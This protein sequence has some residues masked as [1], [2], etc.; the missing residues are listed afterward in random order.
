[1]YMAKSQNQK[2][3]ELIERYQAEIVQAVVDAIKLTRS[4]VLFYRDV[5][6]GLADVFEDEKTFREVDNALRRAV[7]GLKLGGVTIRKIYSDTDSD[8]NSV[9]VVTFGVE[10]AE[11]QVRVLKEVASLFGVDPYYRYNEAEGEFFDA[12]PLYLYDRDEVYVVLH[13]LVE[14]WVGCRVAGE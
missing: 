13:N 2:E 11:E 3:V 10:L 4:C 8:F 1:M 14:K 7:D 5:Y 12:M 9:V 6:Y